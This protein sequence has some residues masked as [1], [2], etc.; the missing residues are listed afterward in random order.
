VFLSETFRQKRIANRAWKWDIDGSA[1]VDVAYFRC[2]EAKL[3]ASKS[4]RVNRYARHEH[5]SCSSLSKCFIPETLFNASFDACTSGLD[6]G[7]K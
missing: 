7:L 2:F 6:S 4:V 1:N 5:S 3:P